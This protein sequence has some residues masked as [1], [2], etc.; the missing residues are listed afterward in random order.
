MPNQNKDLF[1]NATQ[2]A[3][4]RIRHA[5]AEQSALVW[6]MVRAVTCAFFGNDQTNENPVCNSSPRKV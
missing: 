3:E 5:R 6:F 4:T 1:A 2:I